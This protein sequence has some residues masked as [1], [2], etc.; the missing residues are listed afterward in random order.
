M[1]RLRSVRAFDKDAA[2]VIRTYKCNRGTI[3]IEPPCHVL[4]VQSVDWSR[5]ADAERDRTVKW[6]N[7]FTQA[8]VQL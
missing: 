2:S 1:F 6:K 5:S 8:L 4:G 3:N 7:Y